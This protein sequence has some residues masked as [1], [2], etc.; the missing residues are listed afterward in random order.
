MQSVNLTLSRGGLYK[1]QQSVDFNTMRV[2]FTLSILLCSG[3]AP[4]FS[5]SGRHR[6]RRRVNCFLNV[7]CGKDG[8][9]HGEI[10]KV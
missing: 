8:I 9:L 1:H 4:L 10:V 7:K 5:A 3:D 6:L 2:K